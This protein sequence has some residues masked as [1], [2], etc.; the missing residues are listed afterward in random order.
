MST[1]IESETITRLRR[2]L[3]S[4]ERCIRGELKD[5]ELLQRWTAFAAVVG[6]VL[7][8]S[9]TDQPSP[10]VKTTLAAWRPG[11]GQGR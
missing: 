1:L 11:G 10:V 4:I 3:A 7:D 9:E 6:A 2:E 5:D 8:A